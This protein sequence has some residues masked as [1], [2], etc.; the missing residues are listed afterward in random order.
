MTKLQLGIKPANRRI[1]S[2]KQKVKLWMIT[3]LYKVYEPIE[4]S[5]DD[6]NSQA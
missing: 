2:N 4:L 5:K 3:V 1:Q 6:Y